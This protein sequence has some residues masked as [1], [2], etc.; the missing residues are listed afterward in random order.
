MNFGV[1]NFLR[2]NGLDERARD[3]DRLLAGFA[4]EMAAGLAGT[5]SSLPMIPA[6]LSVDRPVPADRPVI[7]LDAGGTNLRVGVVK[8]DAA[9]TPHISQF[10]RHKMPGATAP[11]PD[12]IDELCVWHNRMVAHLRRYGAAPSACAC[13]DADDCPRRQ[14]IDLYRRAESSLGDLAGQL[15]FLRRHAQPSP[16]A[17]AQRGDAHG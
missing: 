2:A 15:T 10:S 3:S 11:S 4:A 8:F 9:G 7:V 6:Y 1:E 14:A 16:A 12:F 13:P 5:P 17:S